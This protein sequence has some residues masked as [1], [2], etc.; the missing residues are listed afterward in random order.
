M[1]DEVERAL[2][3]HHRF[4]QRDGE[5]VP[6]ETIFEASV[7]VED[8]TVRVQNTL[9]TL[10]AAVESETVAPVVEEGWLETF[11]R[12]V[13]DLAGVTKT[14]PVEVRSVEREQEIVRV[15]TDL[16]PAP[17]TVGE[18]VVAIVSFV[19]G[20]WVEGIIPGY[21]YVDRVER[22]RERARETAQSE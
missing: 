14:E 18:D 8:G 12:R 10:D 4:E 13:V 3:A 21:D 15:V 9:P 11:E 19:E 7:A 22:V 2:E 16:E 20:T 1:T 6:T 5:F 17:G